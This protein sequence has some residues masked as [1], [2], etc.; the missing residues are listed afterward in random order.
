MSHFGSVL[1]GARPQPLDGDVAPETTP[2]AVPQALLLGQACSP[3]PGAFGG[4]DG[5]GRPGREGEPHR[6]SAK[7][8]FS[9]R[10]SQATPGPCGPGTQPVPVRVPPPCGCPAQSHWPRPP[11]D[12]SPRDR[13]PRCPEG[14]LPGTPRLRPHQTSGFSLM[15]SPSHRIWG[16]AKN[17][18]APLLPRASRGV[19]LR[20]P[21]GWWGREQPASSG[22][23]ALSPL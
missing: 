3:G 21:R 8:E 23:T 10:S 7:R 4:S 12:R 17:Q 16:A 9:F 15:F 20:G 2:Q 5:C 14:R 6:Q 19:D 1:R 18:G 11:R 22:P 13:R